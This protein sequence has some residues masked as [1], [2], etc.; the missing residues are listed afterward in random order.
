MPRIGTTKKTQDNPQT[1]A[2]NKPPHKVPQNDD[3]IKLP[4][5]WLRGTCRAKHKGFIEVPCFSFGPVSIHRKPATWWEDDAEWII[6]HHNTGRMMV[7]VIRLEDA[8]KV[9]DVFLVHCF[10]EMKMKDI[11]KIRKNVPKWVREWSH[12]CRHEKKYV[13]HHQYIEQN[14]EGEDA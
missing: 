3:S 6:T 1:N 10:K 5:G 13:D 2:T 8:F 4:P 14:K 9:A 11:D 12:H 7:D